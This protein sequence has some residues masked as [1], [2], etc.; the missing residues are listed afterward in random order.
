MDSLA[1]SNEQFSKS[2][3]EKAPSAPGP[4][5]IS[6]STTEGDIFSFFVLQ[7]G[8]NN[9]L[10]LQA[11]N[12]S[13]R[14][15]SW[16]SPSWR[17]WSRW[18]SRTWPTTPPLGRCTR[19]W[20]A[21]TPAREGPTPAPPADLPTSRATRPATPTPA[22]SLRSTWG[23]PTPAPAMWGLTTGWNHWS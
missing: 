3:L 22:C 17:R 6:S 9:I 20:A 8:K 10:F 12:T 11:G 7:F 13:R 5:A 14:L 19:S 21:P 16:S 2:K 18:W 23:A 15:L 1:V 4:S